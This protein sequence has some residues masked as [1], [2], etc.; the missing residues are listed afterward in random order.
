MLEFPNNMISLYALIF[1]TW[2]CHLQL[3]EQSNWCNFI[4]W[5]EMSEEFHLKQEALPWEFNI[6]HKEN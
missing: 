5:K 1:I 4:K 2:L 6:F 3:L